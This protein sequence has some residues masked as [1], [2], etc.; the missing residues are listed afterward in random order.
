[1]STSSSTVSGMMFVFTPPC[2][3]VGANVVCVHAWTIRASPTSGTLSKNAL[4]CAGSSSMDAISGG[5]SEA[6]TKRRHT[7]CNWV[8]GWNSAMRRTTSAAFTSALSVRR[9]IDPCPGVP[10]TRSLHQYVPFSATMTGSFGPLIDG[11]GMRKPPASVTTKSARTA[12]ARSR[13]SHAAPY[14]PSAS[15]SATAR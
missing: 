2:T 4:T 3:M 14:V 12:S 9:G 11:R 10:W 1:M 15:S 6:S 8:S 5:R 7:S 13:S